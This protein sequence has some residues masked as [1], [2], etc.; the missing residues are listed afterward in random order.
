MVCLAPNRIGVRLA[1]LSRE[2]IVEACVLAAAQTSQCCDA[3]DH[4]ICIVAPLS[5][6]CIAE[7]LLSSDLMPKVL[8]HLV[9]RDFGRAA[10]VCRLWSDCSKELSLRMADLFISKRVHMATTLLCNWK[11]A[12][13]SAPGPI[14]ARDGARGGAALLIVGSCLARTEKIS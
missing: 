1:G 9:Y 14:Y 11:P 6:W 4:A 8:V 10:C 3:L 2:Q 13:L 5:T 12:N 7:I